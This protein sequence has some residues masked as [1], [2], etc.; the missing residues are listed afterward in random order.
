MKVVKIV[1]NEFNNESRDERE[2]GICQEMQA[3]VLVFAKE[4]NGK[5][6]MI[7][8]VDGFKVHRCSTRPL[9]GKIPNI[10]NRL[11]A[12]FT[13]TYFVRKSKPDIISG[14]DLVGLTIGWISTWFVNKKPLL[15]YD[16]HEFELGRNIER[17]RLQKTGIQCWEHFLI[18]RSALVIMVNDSIADAVKK[19]YRLKERPLVIRNIPP[20]WD[21]NKEECDSIRR[22]IEADMGQGQYLLYHG[23]VSRGRGIEKPIKILTYNHEYRLLI[24]GNSAE[25]GYINNLKNYAKGLGVEGRVLFHKAVPH[26]ILWQYVGAA[27]LSVMLIEGKSE[28]YYFGLP[29]KLFESIQAGVPVLSSNFPEFKRIVEGYHVGCTCDPDDE[30]AIKEALKKILDEKTMEE[31]KNSALAAAK[32][33]CWENERQKLR[34]AYKRLFLKRKEQLYR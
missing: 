13:W 15:I 27:D 24:L 32:E 7:E 10:I 21:I 31:Y 19:I 2:L 3:E 1:P 20:R 25:D 29:N 30:Y 34:S 22:K 11:A 17:T 4:K 26:E 16:S 6:N 14:H 33:L 18:G 8:M 12:L 23:A 5:K 9:G 28:S